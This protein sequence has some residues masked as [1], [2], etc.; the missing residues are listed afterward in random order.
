MARTV[1]LAPGVLRIPTAPGSLVNSFAFLEADGTVTQVDAGVKGAPRRIVA[2]L[3]EVGKT[4]ADVARILLTHAHSDHVGGARELKER[5]GGRV[6]AH[7]H[8]APYARDGVHPPIDRG[9]FFGRVLAFATRG[10]APVGVDGTFSDGQRLDVGGGL[11]VVHTPG[12]TPGHVS[13]LHEP[14]GVLVTGD[15]IFNVRGLT[16]SPAFFCSNVPASR[17]TA[18][19]LGDLDYEVAAFTHGPEV[20]ENAREAVRAFLRKRRTVRP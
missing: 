14:S 12:H 7:E 11:R 2:A 4:P 19:R 15:A 9:T 16:Y 17:E 6:H 20:R 5:T 1:Q 3:A 18:A 13:F 8:E 10:S